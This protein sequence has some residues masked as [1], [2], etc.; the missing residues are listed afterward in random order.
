MDYSI[1][2]SQDY[3]GWEGQDLIKQLEQMRDELTEQILHH[4]DFD[5][6]EAN[7]VINRIKAK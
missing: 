2:W 7:E 5:F 6:R 1:R 4:E 3:P